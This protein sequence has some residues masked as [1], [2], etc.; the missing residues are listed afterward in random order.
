MLE[1]KQVGGAPLKYPNI[2]WSDS[3]R[4]K[5]CLTS[6]RYRK[7]DAHGKSRPPGSGTKKWN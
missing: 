3:G 7:T 4:G 5:C 1:E 6:T 2:I